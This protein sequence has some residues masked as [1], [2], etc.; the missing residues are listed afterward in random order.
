MILCIVVTYNASKW[1]SK[2]F[3][4]LVN[5]TIPIKVV[6]MDN[7]S[8]DETPSIIRKN[9]PSVEVIET[10]INLGFT[11][12]NNLGFKR[13][14]EDQFKYVFLLNQDAWIEKDTLNKLLEVFEKNPDAGIV[15]PIHL[16]GNSTGLDKGFAL[17]LT[18][19]NT[20]K[21]ISDLYIGSLKSSYRTNFVNAAA[22]LINRK[23][24]Q[25]VGVFDSSLFCH[26]GEDD[27]YC[28]RVRYHNFGIYI[29][30]EAT[31]CHDREDRPKKRPQVFDKMNQDLIKKTQYSNPFLPDSIITDKLIN[32]KRL[33]KRKVIKYSLSLNFKKLMDFKNYYNEE[34]NFFKLIQESRESY[35]NDG[36]KWLNDL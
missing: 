33:Q 18:P 4:S 31:I 11:K 2:C 26:Y 1:I 14:I 32:L 12:A 21:F 34:L 17:Y 19:D 10:G 6:V 8:M 20:P 22:W 28:Q 30:T 36:L 35:L 16:N 5:S 7:G 15:S 25:K 23:C 13:F 27:N 3:G 9:Y 24:I 29:S